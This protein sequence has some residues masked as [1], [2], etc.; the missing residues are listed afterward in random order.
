MVEAAPAQWPQAAH[1]RLCEQRRA[2][3]CGLCAHARRKPRKDIAPAARIRLGV[4]AAGSTRMQ[5]GRAAR[6]CRAT[7]APSTRPAPTRTCWRARWS[8]GPRSPTT[9]TR[10]S[11][12]WSTAASRSTTA[13]ASQARRPLRSHLHRLHRDRQRPALPGVLPDKQARA[14]QPA[15][16]QQLYPAARQRL[17][18]LHC[19]Q[20]LRRDCLRAAGLCAACALFVHAGALGATSIVQPSAPSGAL[21]DGSSRA[22]A[23]ARQACLQRWWSRA[24]QRTR[25]ARRATA[26]STTCGS[27]APSR[28]AAADFGVFRTLCF[29][30]LARCWDLA[31]W[32]GAGDAGRHP[33][34]G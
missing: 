23:R 12:R 25:T 5:R 24:M 31:P 29:S 17:L 11:A 20:A 32:E 15:A 30:C 2:W 4:G 33:S 3:L 8:A 6:R 16:G 22:R 19:A 13:P 1:G 27:T 34:R 28:A 10:I 26:S 21:A 9:R 14:C 7:W 18:S